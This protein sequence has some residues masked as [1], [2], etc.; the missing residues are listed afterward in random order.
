MTFRDLLYIIY[1]N[2][3]ALQTSKWMR[4]LQYK[5]IRRHLEA[6]AEAGPDNDRQQMRIIHICGTVQFMFHGCVFLPLEPQFNGGYAMT[7]E[8]KSINESQIVGRI[9]TV[10]ILGNV[11]LTA[12]K[13]FA[14]IIGH[15]GA[16]VSDAIHSMSD[17]FATFIAFLGVKLSKKKADKNHPYG[18]ERLEC[19]ASIILGAILLTT[20]LGIGI[21]GIEK[22]IAGNYNELN[23]PTAIALI[24]A[25]VSIIVKEGMFWYTRH[26]AKILDSAA[27]MADAWHHR[28]DAF[29]SIG[30][31]IGIGGAMLGFPVLDPIASVIICCFILKVAFDILKDALNKMLDT[32]CNDEYEQT[33]ADYIK[34]QDGVIRLD[35]LRTRMFGN[36]IYI[37]TEIAVDGDLSLRDAHDIAERVHDKVEADF[38]NTKH[39]MIHVNPA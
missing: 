21:S 25:I 29:S 24:A 37:D 26:Y 30:S 22:I 1:R 12:F 28:S 7:D 9:S 4:D 16:M 39:I 23:T 35:L 2:L 8:N 14:G 36:K 33:L 3:F 15:S 31:L 18:H 6:D 17:V 11:L 27:F 5:L 32:S 20:G 38:P 34:N 19:V 10:G 13:L